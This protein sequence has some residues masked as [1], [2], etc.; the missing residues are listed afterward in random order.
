MSITQKFII[1]VSCLFLFLA[2]AAKA[3]EVYK[4]TVY[5][6]FKENSG[7]KKIKENDSITFLI[8]SEQLIFN[9]RRDK[10]RQINYDTI[11]DSLISISEAKEKASEYLE[12][13][14]EEKK[15]N[16]KDSLDLLIIKFLKNP[17]VYYYNS[18]FKEIY[19]FEMVDSNQGFLYPV[20]WN[21]YIE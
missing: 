21:W 20:K 13:S 5:I 1:S 12:R 15:K 14:A 4:E 7:N 3:Q 11:K 9:S 2:P 16:A 19:V 8:H 17:G 18:Y 6:F 10:R